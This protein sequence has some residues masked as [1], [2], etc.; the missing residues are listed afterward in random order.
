MDDSKPRTSLIWEPEKPKTP[1]ALKTQQQLVRAL[2]ELLKAESR[3]VADPSVK[4][5]GVA[6]VDRKGDETG[7]LVWKGDLFT[8]LQ[9][10]GFQER[11]EIVLVTALDS[12]CAQRKLRVIE[13]KFDRGLNYKNL[14]IIAETGLAVRGYAEPFTHPIIKS[15]RFFFDV[16]IRKNEIPGHEKLTL[17]PGETIQNLREAQ[18]Q[19]LRERFGWS[20]EVEIEK[21]LRE[22]DRR[23]QIELANALFDIAKG[24]KEREAISK[25]KQ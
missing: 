4:I 16:P 13:M 1:P 24:V 10:L 6:L 5:K 21:K 11:D 7:R 12:L 18:E 2:I 8:L 23:S 15:R 22:E 3:F 19:K 14:L 9:V 17:M 20:N 25:G